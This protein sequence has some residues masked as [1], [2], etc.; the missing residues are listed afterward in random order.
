MLQQTSH[1][2]GLRPYVSWE[3]SQCGVDLDYAVSRTTTKSGKMAFSI[4]GSAV[5]NSLSKLIK[6]CLV[7]QQ[8]FKK[9]LTLLSI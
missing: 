7:Q 5:W 2:N 6:M 8:E 4:A 1:P 9:K 3:P